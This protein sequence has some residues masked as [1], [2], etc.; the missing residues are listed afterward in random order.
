MPNIKMQKAGA[1]DYFNAGFRAASDLERSK[2]P[3]R[4]P[5]Q[6]KACGHTLS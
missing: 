5:N 3:R 2:D 6:P 4:N 1:A